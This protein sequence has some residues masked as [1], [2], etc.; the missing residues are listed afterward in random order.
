MLAKGVWSCQM[1]YGVCE[2]G[3]VRIGFRGEVCWGVGFASVYF[4]GVGF[5]FSIDEFRG[6]KEAD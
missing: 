2:R 3:I 6:K 4:R 5:F 1:C